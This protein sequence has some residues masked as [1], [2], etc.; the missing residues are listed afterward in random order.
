[1]SS[2]DESHV[3]RQH[4]V[5][6]YIYGLCCPETKQIRYIGKTIRPKGRLRDH[7]NDKSKTH[8]VNWIKSLKAKGLTPSMVILE[9][10]EDGA[11][12][13]EAE[14]RWIQQGK[15]NGWDLV[16][17]TTGGDGV[18]NLSKESRERIRQAWIGRKHTE[19]TKRKLSKASTGRKHSEEWKKNMSSKMKGRNIAWSDTL[20]KVN[21]KFD[22]KKQEEVIELINSGM[23]VKDVA[24]KYGVHRTT[25]SK[26]KKGIYHK[27]Y[28]DMYGN[29]K[30]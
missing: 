8:K 12:W 18:P 19:E 13:E 2:I 10:L 22:K 17:G 14:I 26:I 25:I 1:M 16:N 30:K 24:E 7:I 6:I 21:R 20:S 23:K 27:R 28:K 11:N 3:L 4:E 9:T 15:N 29:N 5:M